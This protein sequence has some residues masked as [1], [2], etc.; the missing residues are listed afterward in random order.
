LPG[1][2][3]APEETGL[4]ALGSFPVERPPRIAVRAAA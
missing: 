2:F 1:T 3:L 4:R